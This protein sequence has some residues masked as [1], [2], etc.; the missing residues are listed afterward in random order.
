MNKKIPSLWPL[1]LTAVVCILLSVLLTLMFCYRFLYLDTKNEYERKIS[2]LSEE[3]A[4]REDPTAFF[5]LPDKAGYLYDLLT[6]NA[7]GIYEEGDLDEAMLRGLVGGSGDGAARY[8]SAEE[9]AAYRSSS[10]TSV[11]GVGIMTL[12]ASEEELIVTF[13]EPNGPAG[14]AGVETGDRIAAVDGKRLSEI[15]AASAAS[16][17]RGE[18]GT[19][20]TLTLKKTDGSERDAA[21]TRDKITFTGV[22]GEKVGTIGYIRIV[23]TSSDA[24]TAFKKE[25]DRLTD[26]GVK[27]FVFDLR[28]TYDGS[29]KPLYQMLDYL[30][31]D[32]NEAGEANLIFE[33]VD[34]RNNRGQYPASDGHDTALPCHVLIDGQTAKTGEVF[35]Q[36]LRLLAGAEITG[37]QSAGN[38]S[39]QSLQT[40]KDGSAVIY[41]SGKILLSDGTDLTGGV[42][43]DRAPQGD[44]SLRYAPPSLDLAVTEIANNYAKPENG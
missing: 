23:S 15:G 8:M 24:V 34:I 5:D 37:E 29:L 27:A 16:M 26:E 20:V 9:Y 3:L 10:S 44:G 11:V 38:G 22:S 31:P 36:A 13:V 25:V 32:K 7:I 28:G 41:T 21:I 42:K 6:Q 43:P 40:L 14:K 17:I 18:K 39:I 35:A 33:T 19:S 4:P 2:A 30:L 12:T 1:I